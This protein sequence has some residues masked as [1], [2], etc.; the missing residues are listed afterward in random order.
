MP[1]ARSITLWTAQDAALCYSQC[2]IHIFGKRVDTC[3]LRLDQQSNSAITICMRDKVKGLQFPSI[4]TYSKL[5]T[6]KE[7][8]LVATAE[9]ILSLPSLYDTLCP[10]TCW[11]NSNIYM[12]RNI[13]VR[14]YFAFRFRA[15]RYS[16][17]LSSSHVKSTH[18]LSLLYAFSR[19]PGSL[20]L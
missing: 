4:E 9:T 10:E 15:R 17:V 16:S 13:T 14:P 2:L 5:A 20:C 3:T 12:V 6:K 1:P 7:E 11:Y 19:S 8:Q 18:R